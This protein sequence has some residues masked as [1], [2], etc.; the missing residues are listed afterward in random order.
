MAPPS[1]GIIALV[2]YEAVGE[3]RIPAGPSSSA[4]V[5]TTPARPGNS[6]LE[7]GSCASGTRTDEAS[8]KTSE[9]PVP[10]IEPVTA[11]PRFGRPDL[12]RE[13][14][15]AG[16]H[17]GRRFRTRTATLRP[18]WSQ[19]VPAGVPPALISA[20]STRPKR[21]LAAAISRPG[22]AGSLLSA[23]TQLAVPAVAAF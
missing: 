10:V 13:P 11:P 22:V 8:T 16:R 23:A 15:P 4:S 9:R 7:M 20:P 5:F 3:I 6:P 1:T 19:R 12:P 2:M 17:Q 21:S 18:L 14:E